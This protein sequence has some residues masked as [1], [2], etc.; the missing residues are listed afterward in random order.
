MT[1][2]KRMNNKM[3]VEDAEKPR[4]SV[5]LS[6]YNG[7]KYLRESIDSILNQSFSDFEFL[8]IDDGSTDSSVEIVESY[9]DKRIRLIKNENNL[10]LITS[11][12][13]GLSLAQGEFIARQDA[14]DIAE[15]SRFEKLIEMLDADPNLKLVGSNVVLIDPKGERIGSWVYPTSRSFARWGLLFNNVVAHSSSMYVREDALRVGGYSLDYPYA[16]D[17]NLWSRLAQ[18]GDIGNCSQAL[19][20]Y[21]VH[22]EAVSTLKENEQI[23]IRRK[24]SKEN[25]ASLVEGK[26]DD[27][28]V[29]FLT[30]DSGVKNRSTGSLYV[31]C[32]FELK[33]IFLQKYQ[34]S[35]SERE[36]I[37]Q[38]IFEKVAGATCRLG[39]LSRLAIIT[40]NIFAFP[41]TYWTKMKIVNLIFS[42]EFKQRIKSLLGLSSDKEI[43]R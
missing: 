40:S 34:V 3:S 23:S 24:I 1:N 36:N 41:V 26:L 27:D 7:E 32:L 5:L 14:D 42:D 17:Y 4:L 13:K 28:I 6:V 22:D 33:S 30:D 18:I 31:K 43:R 2:S 11:L 9:K 37:E 20:R 16:E 25:I 35:D 12:N 21:R 8:I 10:G 38:Y 15:N 39:L 29:W 19:Q